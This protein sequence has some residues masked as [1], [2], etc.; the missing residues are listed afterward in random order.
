MDQTILNYLKKRPW[1]DDWS[2]GWSYN[3]KED[4]SI[5]CQDELDELE[6]GLEDPDKIDKI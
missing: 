2:N 5:S 4:M 6:Q 3:K 1:K